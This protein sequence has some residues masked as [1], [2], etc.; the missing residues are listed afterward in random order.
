MKTKIITGTILVAVVG[1]LACYYYLKNTKAQGK[2]IEETNMDAKNFSIDE[3]MSNDPVNTISQ[4]WSDNIL[5]ISVVG[6]TQS[7]GGITWVSS[8][9]KSD[10]STIKVV[11]K[12]EGFL[13][14][15][16]MIPVKFNFSIT[17]LPKKDYKVIPD[18]S[19]KWKN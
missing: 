4:S 17:D 11:A 18:I 2:I 3:V 6:M 10:N 15:C 19:I 16:P 14:N 8:I 12:G 7:C 9:A 13:M 5:K 1:L